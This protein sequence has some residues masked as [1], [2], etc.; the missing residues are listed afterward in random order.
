MYIYIYIYIHTCTYIYIYICNVRP[1]VIRLILSPL[2]S[3]DNDWGQGSEFSS[4]N[5]CR[6][7]QG[8]I[9]YMTCHYGLAKLV[10]ITPISLWVMA[11]ISI[12][13]GIITQ[14]TTGGAPPCI[15]INHILQGLVYV[16]IEHHPHIGDISSPT[17]TCLGDVKQIL[18]I[19]HLPNP[20][21]TMY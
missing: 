10:N 7:I 6:V 13:I 4:E 8:A 12:V 14:L 18:R 20:V 9:R 17:D 16:L 11:D 1:P 19:G 2:F 21:L 5:S 3:K 15:G